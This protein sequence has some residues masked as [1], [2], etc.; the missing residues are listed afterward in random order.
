M[1]R[2]PSY[3][4]GRNAFNSRLTRDH[5]PADIRDVWSRAP[6]PAPP[7]PAPALPPP[8]PALAAYLA[9]L[10][11]LFAPRQ[12]VP[13]PAACHYPIPNTAPC[14]T[15][16]GRAGL[17]RT[18]DGPDDHWLCHNCLVASG[19]MPRR[20][21]QPE[22]MSEAEIA[23]RREQRRLAE[24]VRRWRG[25]PLT[26]DRAQPIFLTVPHRQDDGLTV[27]KMVGKLD[28]VNVA[29][30]QELLRDRDRI[31]RKERPTDAWRD[32]AGGPVEPVFF[33]AH[34][35]SQF[36]RKLNCPSPLDS[37]VVDFLYRNGIHWVFCYE[38]REDAD[39][40]REPGILRFAPIHRFHRSPFA[41]EAEY[42]DRWRVYLSEDQWERLGDVNEHKRHGN[43]K[44]HVGPDRELILNSPYIPQDQMLVLRRGKKWRRDQ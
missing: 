29:M 9:T 18:E 24:A 30:I 43:V 39:G 26:W 23:R 14:A 6:A 44:L 28:L 40:R 21:S 1:A 4:G 12:R 35:G 22:P 7:P 17:F 38:R 27:A 31:A 5:T 10:R 37:V 13:S 8:D 41:P 3:Y 16:C 11:R 19:V 42:D 36:H 25:D 15:G 32:L 33:H 20:A 34:S 2:T